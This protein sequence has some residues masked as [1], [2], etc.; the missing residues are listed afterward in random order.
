MK[1]T[2]ERLK[3]F[4]DLAI[5][6]QL[7]MT[8]VLENVHD[9]HNISAVM[10]TCDSVGIGEVHI[11]YTDGRTS[12]ENIKL[13][14]RSSAGTRKWVDVLLYDSVESCINKLSNQ[15]SLLGAYLDESSPSVY[16]LDLSKPVA[17]VFGNE[18]KGLSD[19]MVSH[20]DGSFFIPQ[21]GMVRSLNISVACAISLY[22]AMRQRQEK[23]LY[24]SLQIDERTELF[25]EYKR[26][27]DDPE[28]GW[29][30]KKVS[31]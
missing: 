2:P 25:E 9:P 4:Q 29:T 31:D 18:S 14:K 11:V 1:F 12:E 27:H 22:E 15:F 16:S 10:R 7:D 3:R 30:A 23:G 24:N 21:F 8:V 6:R 26:R 20:L 17:L 28:Y 19:E 13:G 5:N